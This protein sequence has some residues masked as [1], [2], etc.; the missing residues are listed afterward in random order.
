MGAAL[1]GMLVGLLAFVNN[2]P[3]SWGVLVA[4][5]GAAGGLSRGWQPGYRLGGWIEQ[6]IG[7]QHFLQGLGMALG[8]LCGGALGIA[9]GWAIIPIILGPVLGAKLGKELGNKLWQ[10]GTVAGWD[11]IWAGVLAVCTAVLGWVIAGLAGTGG[12]SILGENFALV[13]GSWGVRPLLTSL[14]SGAFC[15]GLGGLVAGTFADFI[16]GLFGLTD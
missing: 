5:G 14:L 12:L 10:A 4:L 3:P 1:P 9:F 15:S 8:I 2:V 7:W 6:Y 13:L 16:A 11:R